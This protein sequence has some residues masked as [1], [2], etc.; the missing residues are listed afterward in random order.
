MQLN[1][2][3]SMVILGDDF[4]REMGISEEVVSVKRELDA[5]L[6]ELR[7]EADAKEKKIIL[8]EILGLM[9]ADEKYTESEEQFMLKII[10]AFGMDSRD[11]NN[12]YSLLEI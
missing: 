9:L 1:Q 11:V 6:E 5:V 3:S 2:K 10:E 8:F 12:M 7:N 4:C